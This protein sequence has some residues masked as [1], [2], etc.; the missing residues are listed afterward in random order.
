MQYHVN[1]NDIPIY[2]CV[3]V[4]ICIYY[5]YESNENNIHYVVFSKLKPMGPVIFIA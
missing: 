3:C 1:Y 2:L 4:P 5:V